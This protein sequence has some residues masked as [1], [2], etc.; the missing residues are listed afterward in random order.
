MKKRIGF[1]LLF[2]VILCVAVAAA[3]C[4]S[5]N[6]SS[7]QPDNFLKTASLSED[8]TTLTMIFDEDFDSDYNWGLA[9]LFG[10]ALKISADEKTNSDSLSQEI[11]SHKWVFEGDENESVW[12]HFY[13]TD[14]ARD[15]TPERCVYE[16][17][18]KDG[19]LTIRSINSFSGNRTSYSS[20]NSSYYF[21][22]SERIDIAENN[23][24][25][26]LFF[27]EPAKSSYKWKLEE[28]PTGI[29]IEAIGESELPLTAHGEYIWRA[30]AFDGQNP[31]NVTLTLK[32]SNEEGDFIVEVIYEL[33]V[34]ENN[35]ISILSASHNSIK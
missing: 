10:N 8:K 7:F 24:S 27:G 9:M 11:G 21:T 35:E 34:D 20:Y 23:T 18:N 12:L 28:N 6:N 16:I 25:L 13:Y 26:S 2:F 22:Y 17:E 32:H 19:K 3:G 30:W 29:L 33:H 4:L 5:N 1:F 14:H 15:Y 31:G